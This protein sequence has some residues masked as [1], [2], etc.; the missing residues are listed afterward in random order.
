MADL[1]NNEAGKLDPEAAG[2]ETSFDTLTA[3]IGGADLTALRC[4]APIGVSIDRL[5]VT[6]REQLRH[7]PQ[8]QQVLVVIDR[9]KACPRQSLKWWRWFL[10]TRRTARRLA[11]V[12]D[13]EKPSVFLVWPDLAR[14]SLVVPWRRSAS[15]LRWARASG[16]LGGSDGD[17]WLRSTFLRSPLH[18]WYVQLVG[19]VIMVFTL[20]RKRRQRSITGE[21]SI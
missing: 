9:R 15:A 19:P 16:V 12:L 4:V 2:P 13:A 17:R 21:G 6:L 8:S 18:L 14:P 5:A 7:R 11:R 3:L 10:M 20:R 1:R